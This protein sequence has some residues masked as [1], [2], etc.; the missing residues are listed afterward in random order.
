[1][2]HVASILLR[3]NAAHAEVR[4]VKGKTTGRPTVGICPPAATAHALRIIGEV[5][6]RAGAYE[7]TVRT[8]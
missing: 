4:R 8:G 5:S 2:D 1:M 3:I 7:L 6:W